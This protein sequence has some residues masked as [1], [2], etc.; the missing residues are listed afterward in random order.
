MILIRVIRA[1]RQTACYF[2][3]V[4]LKNH[5]LYHFWEIFMTEEDAKKIMEQLKKYTEET[6]SSKE[7]AL[8]ALIDAGL[9]KADGQPTDLYRN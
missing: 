7:K 1:I 4:M 3:F 8:Q 5:L 2:F 6:T 9:V